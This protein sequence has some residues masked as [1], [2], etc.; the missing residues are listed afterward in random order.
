MIVPHLREDYEGEF[1][2]T[3]ARWVDGEKIIERE[4]VPNPV[5]NIHIS[6]RA[7]IL[8]K[9]DPIQSF[10]PTKLAAHRGGL[11]ASKKLQIY[12]INSVVEHMIPDF[13]LVRDYDLIKKIAD[14]DIPEKTTI[15][16]FTKNCIEFPG[17]F[18]PVPHGVATTDIATAIYLAC[19]DGHKEVFILNYDSWENKKF[20]KSI[21][22]MAK[23][24][25]DVQFYIV[26]LNDSQLPEEWKQQINIQYMQFREWISYCDVSV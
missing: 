5:T 18:Y 20:T 17:R 19:F 2:I 6:A 10:N 16:T 22:S 9:P 14:T 4:W 11:L 26:A 25:H 12:G 21:V 1:I 8:C 23:S 3:E 24:Y 15:Y 7:C 13:G